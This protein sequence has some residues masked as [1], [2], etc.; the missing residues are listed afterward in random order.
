V[1]V[2]STGSTQSFWL[3]LYRFHTKVCHS[4]ATPKQMHKSHYLYQNAATML[5][6]VWAFRQ[7]FKPTSMVICTGLSDVSNRSCKV[8]VVPLPLSFVQLYFVK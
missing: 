5:A 8:T 7:C 1:T 2:P 6:A 3:V 4:G